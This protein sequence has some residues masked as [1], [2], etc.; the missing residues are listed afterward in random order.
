[1]YMHKHMDVGRVVHVGKRT[2]KVNYE[3]T[4]KKN[5]MQVEQELPMGI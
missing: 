4:V 2:R 5:Q 1:M 3:G